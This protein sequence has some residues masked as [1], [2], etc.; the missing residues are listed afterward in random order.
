MYRQ[1]LLDELRAKAEEQQGINIVYGKKFTRVLA[2]TDEDVTFEF[3]D[4]EQ[5]TALLLVGADGIHSRLRRER[6]EDISAKYIGLMAVTG[7]VPTASIAFPTTEEV[8]A[9]GL[10]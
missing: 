1:V 4:G 3:A 6:I 9:Q 10:P 7:A 5:K 2:E 8:R